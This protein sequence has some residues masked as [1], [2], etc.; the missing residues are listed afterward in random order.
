MRST[1]ACSSLGTAQY[2]RCWQHCRC[3]AARRS[4]SACWPLLA[5][6]NHSQ[7]YSSLS[8]Q[9]SEIK[10]RTCGC[11]TAPAASASGMCCFACFTLHFTATVS[12]ACRLPTPCSLS[13]ANSMLL[14]HTVP[15]IEQ[16]LG[17]STWTVLAIGCLMPLIVLHRMEQGARQRF[18][19]L[20]PPPPPPQQ[21]VPETTRSAVRLQSGQTIA[22]IYSSSSCAWALVACYVIL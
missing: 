15:P 22:H 17:I 1:R 13:P 16:C 20:Q 8:Q 5:L 6:R 11:C 7:R 14:A 19:R 10:H 9:H 4:A 2:C 3:A 12:P 18:Q 21:Q